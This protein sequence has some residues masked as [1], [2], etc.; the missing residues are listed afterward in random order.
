LDVPNSASVSYVAST[1]LIWSPS[2]TL[3][4][5]SGRQIVAFGFSV[6]MVHEGWEVLT[7][8]W[9]NHV[10]YPFFNKA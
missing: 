9:M 7:L 8:W 10:R 1:A 4:K 3:F 6:I 5:A 2:K